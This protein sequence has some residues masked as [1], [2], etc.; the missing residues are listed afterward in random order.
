MYLC[1]KNSFQFEQKF[2]L[3]HD[4]ISTDIKQ[5]LLIYNNKKLAAFTKKK[6]IY[7]Y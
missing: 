3:S 5:I 4:H 6:N 2:T 7:F 1:N